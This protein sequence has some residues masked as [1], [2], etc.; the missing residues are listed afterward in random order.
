MVLLPPLVLSKAIRYC[1]PSLYSPLFFDIFYLS[2]LSVLIQVLCPSS[3][4]TSSQLEILLDDR[5]DI[6]HVNLDDEEDEV[7]RSLLSR[8]PS[9]VPAPLP[10]QK[11]KQLVMHSSVWGK[12]EKPLGRLVEICFSSTKVEIIDFFI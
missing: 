9:P 4:G 2:L 10:L 1:I 7:N 8:N 12:P 3:P 11:R 5:S 6:S